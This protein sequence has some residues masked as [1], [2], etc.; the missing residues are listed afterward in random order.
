MA[1]QDYLTSL[2][3]LQGQRALCTGATRGIGQ[4]IA[5]ALA[6]AGATIVLAQRDLSNQDTL[7][8]IE[9]LGG[10]VEQI[11][12]DL[13]KP[14]SVKSLVK[15]ATQN[16]RIDI[17]LNCGG[18]QRRNP[19]EDYLDEDWDA[20]LQVNLTAAF[21]LTRDVGKHMLESKR[22]TRGKI[23]NIAS[24]MT[25]QAGVNVPAYAAT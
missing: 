6:S 21:I 13:E 17:L 22:T 24:I 10:Q 7:K 23:I 11:E 14:D 12:C 4:E 20:L 8:E 18:I 1:P 16:G 5:K 19:P 3:G 2:F 9:A 15:R 25:F